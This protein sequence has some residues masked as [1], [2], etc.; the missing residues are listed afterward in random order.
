M[1]D[2]ERW[3]EIFDTIWKNKLRT[4]LTG[5]SV[6]SGI[7]ILVVLLGVGKGME[8]GVGKEFSRD[9]TNLLWIWTDVTSI[10]HNGQNPGRK[11]QL[12]N[13]DYSHVSRKYED[14]LAYGTKMLRRWGQ[15]ISYDKESGGYR[16]EGVVPDFQFIETCT[17]RAGRFVHQGDV[18]AFAKVVVLGYKVQKDLFKNGEDP[19][20]KYVTISN[21]S[22][23]VVG[24]YADPG[25]E[26]EE[27]RGY[28]PITTAQRLFNQGNKVSS[29]AFTIA[30]QSS[31]EASVG[32][33]GSLEKALTTTLKKRHNVASKDTS[34]IGVFNKQEEMKR[35]FDLM[36][37]IR[38]F[39]WGVGIFTI[40]A[41][42][43]GVSNI[44]LIIVKERTK[45]IGVRK[46]IG[47]QPMSIIGMIMHEAIFVT[48][49]SGF[50]GLIFGLALW[51]FVGPLIEIDYIYNP[52]VDFGVAMTT[53]FLLIIAG[54]LAGFFP[55]WRAA[56]IKPI[57]ALREA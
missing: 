39:F 14:H 45:E 57:V 30:P 1:F 44:M 50:T 54:G 11:I 12:K 28:I 4:F 38:L 10:A 43:V 20:G 26:R 6:G 31:F 2:I 49:L 27:S 33:A 19:I 41:G 18:D 8:N 37:M 53:V 46:A 21:I 55:A 42:I 40:I 56:R 32:L 48:A 47:A 3:E 9:A 29:M 23:K 35:Y 13:A 24:V 36:K 34:A 17:M 5:L 25:G 52:S 7:F 16:I 51:E 22:F 15:L